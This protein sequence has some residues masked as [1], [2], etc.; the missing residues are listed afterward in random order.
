[1]FSDDD[2]FE[3]GHEETMIQG[4]S[5]S[6]VELELS[7]LSQS[8]QQN[9]QE[10]QDAIAGLENQM[11][12]VSS[13]LNQLSLSLPGKGES[14]SPSLPDLEPLIRLTSSVDLKFDRLRDYMGKVSGELGG[15]LE[16]ANTRID[17]VEAA[18]RANIP[19]ERPSSR[20][21]QML[22]NFLVWDGR[23]QLMLMVATN[24]VITLLG[25][26]V[27]LLMM[28]VRMPERHH[29]LSSGFSVFFST[30]ATL[31]R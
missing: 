12:Y 31:D 28:P 8:S 25:V 16:L 26:A 13:I 27:L 21:S 7:K 4:N 5:S 30:N 22:S 15:K 1:M 6:A 17:R 24:C 23:T 2:G 20:L 29:E 9:F 10:L 14:S 11:L 3:Q 19:E 18:L